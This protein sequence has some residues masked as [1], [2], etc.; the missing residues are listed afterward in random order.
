M[1]HSFLIQCFGAIILCDMIEGVS[2]HLSKREA[3][4]KAHILRLK[5]LVIARCL[6]MRILT[7]LVVCPT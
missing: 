7:M 1:E 3:E 5:L 6:L 4:E 2:D